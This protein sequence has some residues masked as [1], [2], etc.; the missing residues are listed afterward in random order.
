MEKRHL[1]QLRRD[2]L[3]TLFGVGALALGLSW[4]LNP[5]WMPHWSDVPVGAWIAGGLGVVMLFTRLRSP[6]DD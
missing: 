6:A 2:R 1:Q 3:F 5:G 4:G